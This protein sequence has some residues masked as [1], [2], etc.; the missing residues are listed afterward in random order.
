MGVMVKS[1][2][3]VNGRRFCPRRR[4]PWGM[5]GV[6]ERGSG[7]GGQ[8][9]FKKALS[10]FAFDAACGGEIRH[11]ADL[12]YTVKQITGRLSYPAPYGRVQQAVWGYLKD[13][14]ILLLEE[15]R[16]GAPR[17]APVFVKEYGKYGKPSFRQV[18]REAGRPAGIRWQQRYFT[19]QEA[20]SFR[21]YLERKCRENG[22]QDSYIACY[23]GLQG[24][25]EWEDALQILEG[26]QREYIEG[27]PW[28]RKVAYHRLD[29]RMRG[30]AARLYEAGKYQGNCYFRKAEER[31]AVGGAP[32]M[33]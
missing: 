11:L 31:V 21:A 27:L 24:R 16:S 12:G 10:D 6:S 9:Y 1:K 5:E 25:Q 13:C 30:I 3:S 26:R 7:M 33:P 14:G 22:E 17:E 15:P 2:A 18:N 28:E 29:L 32:G 19:G 20:G 23:F 8:E 4:C